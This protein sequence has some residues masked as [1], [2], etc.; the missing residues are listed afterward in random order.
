MRQQKSIWLRVMLLFLASR[1]LSGTFHTSHAVCWAL[2]HV[3][4]QL[5]EQLAA[6]FAMFQDLWHSMV[7]MSA[8]KCVLWAC[9]R[10]RRD[11]SFVFRCINW[12]R[13]LLPSTH[14]ACSLQAWLAANHSL[15]DTQAEMA[16][17]QA[18]TDAVLNIAEPK[19]TFRLIQVHS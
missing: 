1:Q 16:R 7:Y 5:H 8:R 17:L 11:I 19:V 4:N 12:N 2:V 3:H 15:E 9:T 6:D 14:K 18:L 13:C 10:T